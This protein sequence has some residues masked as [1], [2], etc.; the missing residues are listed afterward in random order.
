MAASPSSQSVDAREQLTL[1]AETFKVE[2]V[3]DDRVPDPLTP[4]EGRSV[5]DSGIFALAV[6][7][8]DSVEEGDLEAVRRIAGVKQ[9]QQLDEVSL[10]NVVRRVNREIFVLDNDGTFN[11][12]HAFLVKK[13]WELD[14]AKQGPPLFLAM[15]P[16][17]HLTA[18]RLMRLANAEVR[19]RA[20]YYCAVPRD[21]QDPSR[22]GQETHIAYV[23]SPRS[24]NH[25]GKPRQAV[26]LHGQPGLLDG[27]VGKRR[28]PSSDEQTNFIQRSLRTSFFSATPVQDSS[29]RSCRQGRCR[30][31]RFVDPD[32]H[33]A[34]KGGGTDRGQW[35]DIE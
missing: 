20:L 14:L 32:G 19:I 1:F 10:E 31:D 22:T 2:H 25:A 7:L 18:M 15:W 21:A 35:V 4:D 30:L 8:H 13:E 33:G 17:G 28:C 5:A 11:R 24:C 12:V 29:P 23:M 9:G 16:S 34:R 3:L 6:L 26:R 27:A